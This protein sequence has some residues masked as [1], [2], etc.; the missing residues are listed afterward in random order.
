MKNKMPCELIRDLL[1]SY[2]DHLTSEVTNLYIEEHLAECEECCRI[3]G[4]MREPYR[5]PEEKEKQ[6]IDFL[7][8]IKKRTRITVLRSM[9]AVM[10]VCGIIWFAKLFIFGTC[11]YSEYMDC[12]VRVNGKQLTVSGSAGDNDLEIAGVRYSEEDGVITISFRCVQ[13]G[14]F[15]SGSITET[16][17]AEKEITE[18][19][20]DNRIVWYRGKAISSV[21]SNVYHT[22]HLYVGNMPENIRTANALNIEKVLGDFTNEL[23]TGKEPYEWKLILQEPFTSEEI[24]TAKEAMR[25]YAYVMLAVIDNLGRVS[26]EYTA[27]QE[28]YMMS[29]TSEEASEFAGENIKVAGADAASLERLLEKAGLVGVRRA[30]PADM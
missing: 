11:A 5:E 23:R 9:L 25:S 18:V 12:S 27:D 24:L 6:E 7:K 10:A 22:R 29:I 19:R 26:Y 8:K 3:L 14:P 2:I 17:S 1:P 13:K 16:Y 20:V 28:E 30:K 21:T 15:Y 4:I